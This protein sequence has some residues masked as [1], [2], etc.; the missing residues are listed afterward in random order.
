MIINFPIKRQIIIIYWVVYIVLFAIVV[1]CHLYEINMAD[2]RPIGTMTMEKLEFPPL[3]KARE[4]SIPL[5]EEIL[6]PFKSILADNPAER[7]DMAMGSFTLPVNMPLN[8]NTLV[9]YMIPLDEDTGKPLET[10]SNIVF[11]AP[12][13]GDAPRIAK[14]LLPWHRRFAED[15]GFSVFSLTIETNLE[16]VPYREKYYIYQEAGWF[17]LIFKIQEHLQK[18]FGLQPRKLLA[19]GE[20]S[21][22]SMVQ[23]MITAYPDKISCAAWNGG[24]R[25]SPFHASSNCRILALNTWGCPGISPTLEMLKDARAQG[26][27]IEN[28]LV[29][30][31]PYTTNR[32]R[33]HN[34]KAWKFHYDAMIDFIVG[35]D[36]KKHFKDIPQDDFTVQ[37]QFIYPV[38]QN[39]RGMAVL[40]WKAMDFDL[41][42]RTEH[43][44]RLRLMDFLWYLY[45]MDCTP[46]FIRYG[47]R[48]K[49]DV[50]AEQMAA[51]KKMADERHQ[52]C[53]FITDNLNKSIASIPST[54]NVLSMRVDYWEIQSQ[55]QFAKRLRLPW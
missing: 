14:G 18:E 10:A 13:N 46:A 43:E 55:T 47:D 45:L 6:R 17:E 33:F 53:V 48:T 1:F 42:A 8:K 22:G 24:V 26:M 39:S 51:M 9:H 2:T 37:D 15:Y 19:V 16:V 54:F 4:A 5:N 28:F 49:P 20:S 32:D 50:L 27:N 11:Y 25:Y 31:D 41:A 7:K 44:S 30:A 29:P 38:P 34:H 21:G 23:N 12:F 52:P 36:W 35:N 3:N 40:L